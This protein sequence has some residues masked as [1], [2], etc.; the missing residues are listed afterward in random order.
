MAATFKLY[1][2]TSSVYFTDNML[3]LTIGQYNPTLFCPS[4]TNFDKKIAL[5]FLLGAV[6]RVYMK[7]YIAC[8]HV[9]K[10][11]FEI[12]NMYC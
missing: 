12:I 9:G 6:A 2:V 3:P 5:V 7:M 1:L 4:R 10:M 8:L 11:F